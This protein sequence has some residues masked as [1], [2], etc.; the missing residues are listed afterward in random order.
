[1]THAP[2]AHQPPKSPRRCRP[3]LVR[4]VAAIVTRASCVLAALALTACSIAAPLVAPTA[5]DT[6]SPTA[7]ATFT[8]TAVPTCTATATP[9]PK[10]TSTPTP[11]PTPVPLQMSI[12]L[13]PAAVRQGHTCRLTVESS[14]PTT[15]EGEYQYGA[16]PFVSEDGLVH[17][18]LL[19]VSATAEIATQPITL[20]VRTEDNRTVT[21][22]TSIQVV[23]ANY[24]KEYITLSP[25]T[26]KLLAPEI[27][28]PELEIVA[29][30]YATY[31]PRIT[32]EGAFVWPIEP[33][34]TSAFGTRRSYGGQVTGF[35]T[36]LDLGA[37]AGTPVLAPAPGVVL[38][39]EALQVRGNAVFVD[40]GAG[41]VSGYYHL[42]E[43][44][45]Q[46]GQQVAAGD[47]LG[48]VGSTGLS[49]GAHLHWE[50]RVLGVAVDPVEWVE[51]TGDW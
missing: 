15:V 48:S 28:R 44:A 51:M 50:I 22:T 18:A 42:T 25:E 49:T 40:H 14:L 20:T 2:S 4:R 26:S 31:S 33:R 11:S 41:V 5:T 47:V 38:A 43:I 34:I 1:V 7:T 30:I 37:P 10:P 36:G 24:E 13:S 3:W 32:W 12:S 6:P 46:P 35:H 8:A 45:V 9:T 23:A 16:L 19:G 17:R 27:T 29:A 39:T 21:L